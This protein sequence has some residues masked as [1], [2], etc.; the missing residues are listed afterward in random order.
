MS[1]T[2]Y[3]EKM[4]PLM[5]QGIRSGKKYTLQYKNV[6]QK[7]RK[8]LLQFAQNPCILLLAVA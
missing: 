7:N 5:L 1:L 4:F 8:K 2:E 6:L 3:A